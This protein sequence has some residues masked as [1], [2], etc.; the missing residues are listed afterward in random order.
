MRRTAGRLRDWWLRR[1]YRE[2]RV[3]SRFIA[4]DVRRDVLVVSVARLEH[5]VILG[6]VRTTNVLY[7]GRGLAKEPEFDSPQELRLNEVWNWT[8][9]D[10]GGLPDGTSIA[11]DGVDGAGSGR[12]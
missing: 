8:G 2:G 3:L 10:W 11:D 5:G 1:R 4:K 12:A 9:Q 7:V 6:Q